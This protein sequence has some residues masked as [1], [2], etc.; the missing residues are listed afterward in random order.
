MSYPEISKN[1]V[2]LTWNMAL[3]VY[4]QRME[5]TVAIL[6]FLLWNI[7]IIQALLSGKLPPILTYLPPSPCGCGNV[8][9][10]KKAKKPYTSN[11]E[12]GLLKWELNEYVNKKNGDDTNKELL[13]QIEQLRMENEYL[14]N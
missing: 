10:I 6:K 11:I 7:C 13:R 8:F 14:K 9:T 4:V 1:G 2:T 5:S 12:A 3:P